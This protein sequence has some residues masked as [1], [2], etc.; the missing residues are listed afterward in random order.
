MEIDDIDEEEFG[1]SRNYFLA[2]E[3]RSSS[4]KKSANKLSDI[5]VVDEQVRLTFCPLN[6]AHLKVCL[7]VMVQRLGV[8]TEVRCILAFDVCV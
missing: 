6:F 7:H 2:K 8:K 1:F 5:E 4:S 3:S